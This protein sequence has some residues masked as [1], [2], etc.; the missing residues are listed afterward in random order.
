METAADPSV[1][2]ARSEFLRTAGGC[3]LSSG[4][5][6]R[7]VIIK[8][9]ARA[10]DYQNGLPPTQRKLPLAGLSSSLSDSLF[11]DPMQNRRRR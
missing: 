8:V 3:E 5:N 4:A 7:G 11:A 2:R 10:L 1:L 6:A 9:H